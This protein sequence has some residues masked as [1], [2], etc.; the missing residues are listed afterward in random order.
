MDEIEAGRAKF[1]EV[2]KKIDPSAEGVIPVRSTDSNFLISITK[3]KARKFISVTE[4]DLVEMTENRLVC[5]AVASQIREALMG[6]A[7]SN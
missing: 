5:D 3:G 6:I 1:M 7:P 4:D 2:L